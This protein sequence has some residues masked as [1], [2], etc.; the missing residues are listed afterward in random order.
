MI[1]RTA[2][3]V[4]TALLMA[5]A[6]HAQDWKAN[7][8]QAVA[9]YQEEQYG[10]ALTLAGQALTQSRSLPVLNQAYSL[11][12]ITAICLE[13]GQ[14]SKGLLVID[15]E[16]KLFEQ[17]EG[18]SGKGYDEAC[19]KR[20]QL[21]HSDN[22]LVRA[23]EANK[24]LLGTREKLFG[25]G[26]HEYVSSLLLYAAILT[27]QGKY[28][29][30]RAPLEECL[31][32]L[33]RYPEAGDEY[34]NA[35]FL[36]GGVDLKLNDPASAEKSFRQ[37]LKLAGPSANGE[38]VQVK[39]LLS[40]ILT[41]RGEVKEVKSLLQDP[42]L[43][44][45]PKARQYLRAAIWCREHSLITEA[46]DLLR[47]AE[48]TLRSAPLRNALL[49]SVLLNRASILIERGEL[50][51]AE[52]GV[53][54]ASEL[55][56]QLFKEGSTEIY[57]LYITRADLLMARSQYGLAE[58]EYTKALELISR[59][60]MQDQAAARIDVARRF[61]N[62]GRYESA[63]TA[64][65]LLANDPAAMGALTERRQV[66]GVTL[67]AESLIE[68]F[69]AQQALDYLVK[70][71]GYSAGTTAEISILKAK[72]QVATGHWSDAVAT[73]KSVTNSHGLAPGVVADA[74]LN[75]ARVEQQ[76]AHY[77]DAE[78]NYR[79]AIESYALAPQ[80][81]TE[82]AQAYNSL[83]TY[84]LTLGNYGSAEELYQGLLAMTPP[85]SAFYT[86][87]LHNLAALYEETRRYDKA[88]E[89]LLKS[90]E[91]D[92]TALGPDHPDYAVSLQNLAVVYQKTGELDQAARLLEQALTIDE[93]NSGKGS[94]TYSAK[95]ANLAS[96]NTDRGRLDIAKKQ[97][98]EALKI[99]TQWLGNTHP[100]VAFN[101]YNLAVLFQ[102]LRDLEA[103][104]A[105][106]R[107]VSGFY[108]REIREL[109][110]ALSESEKAAY[111]TKIS[112]VIDAYQ[113]FALEYGLTHP[114]TVGDLFD[115]RL[116]TKALLLNASTK[117]R[118]RIIE[119]GNPALLSQFMEW[120]AVQER[121]AR[122]YSLPA[123]ELK[124][125]QG[126]VDDLRKRANELSKSLSSQSE[127]FAGEYES[128]ATTWKQV[129]AALKPGEAAV[130]LLRL[131]L[132]LKN[133]S[134][135][136]AAMVVRPELAGPQVV[137]MKNGRKMEGREYNYYR[138]LVRFQ[139]DN[140]RSYDIF[141]KPL[142]GS[143][144]GTTALYF[145]PDGIYNKI[146]LPTLYDPGGRQYLLEK[147]T[148]TLVS[149][150]RELV[151]KPDPPV[152]ENKAALMGY[153]DFRLGAKID[154]DAVRKASRSA[155]DPFNQLAIRLPDLPGTRT[156]VERIN[157]ILSERNWIT[158]LLTGSES[159]ESNVKALASPRLLHIATHGYFIESADA[160]GTESLT[161]SRH[162]MLQSGLL[163]AGAQK[164]L[165]Q[166]S[167]NEVGASGQQDGVLTALEAM[168]LNLDHT[169]L[170]V[171]SACETASGQVRNGEGVYGLQR[172]FLVSGASS[173][174]M[175]LWK[176]DDESTEKLMTAFYRN[177][178]QLGDKAQALRRTQIEIRAQYPDPY[179]WGAFVLMG[180]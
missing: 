31:K 108:L 29:A 132:N 156:E 171:L 153:P 167:L 125:R 76:M 179:Y 168:N 92:R 46:L 87:L 3:L 160:E 99:Q 7:Y 173:I 130:E 34:L 53:Q 16:V 19:H 169:D 137:V 131:R 146:S 170:V 143:L 35:L 133:D 71:S 159:S 86:T 8:D 148:I 102:R 1:R 91:R 83:A 51:E 113:D 57:F 105:L 116:A 75:L 44:P 55:S 90:S 65:Q 110:P 120:Q 96:V 147:F 123:E 5:C 67:Y 17:L 135:V 162:P 11:Q 68:S 172:S 104:H 61:F 122:I 139:I 25:R 9:L 77:A 144:K 23:E 47:L 32:N 10:A 94:L 129:K 128:Q 70:L 81:Q 107:D 121:L 48:S 78:A 33:P 126:T 165:Y 154:Y 98:D 13:S 50:K 63:V 69:R 93:K 42:A 30:A 118:N 174:L 103:A 178:L 58:G 45:D 157:G 112:P 6:L 109:F 177:W 115:F 117:I 158:Q 175:S 141:W 40:G 176:V 4:L 26:S 142:E 106:F 2:P 138:N 43:P 111:Y 64:I 163:L 119:G 89:L 73:L 95:L 24:E 155:D 21:L 39:L 152:V 145:S 151:R 52:G 134:I 180:K 164:Y 149:N 85:E 101:K 28:Q 49:Y 15:E 14:A 54:E 127:V 41:D 36:S 27:E 38:S 114:E 62:S 22:Q 88:R 140:V 166:R 150:T 136:Y 20:V 12:L 80:A 79:K 82:L 18:K 84:Y 161:T 124:R 59:Q 74:S 72:A 60:P 97:Y 56:A 66:E 100:D 37:Y